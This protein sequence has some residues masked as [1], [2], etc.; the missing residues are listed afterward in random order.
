MLPSLQMPTLSIPFHAAS[1][2]YGSLF[3]PVRQSLVDLDVQTCAV[4]VSGFLAA[5]CV[6]RYVRDRF[7]KHDLK[8]RTVFITG[9]DTGFGNLLAKHLDKR[10]AIVVA[11]CLT[12]SGRQQLQGE[13]SPRLKTISLD[14]TKAESIR[15]ARDFV[16]QMSPDGVWSIVNNAGILDTGFAE[17][18]TLNDY[19]RVI[20]VN[21]LGTVAVTLDF[22]PLVRKAH[23]RI[24]NV[25]SVAGRLSGPGLASYSMS[26]FGVEAFS[27]SLRAE[28]AGFGVS[29]HIIEPG[30][31]KT[32][33]VD[34]QVTK[35]ILAR[36]WDGLSEPVKAAYGEGYAE[37]FFESSKELIALAQDPMNIVHAMT[38]AIT[39]VSPH[40]RYLVGLDANL[41]WRWLAASPECVSDWIFAVLE[42][43]PPTA[44]AAPYR[45]RENFVLGAIWRALPIAAGIGA[46]SWMRSRA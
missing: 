19:R 21:T 37:A 7:R 31:A 17:W 11:G 20:E 5:G 24:V 32:P 23:G 13:S 34:E 30:F 9:C 42:R 4:F 27:D 16:A 44:E 25:A 18:T 15:A 1:L 36:K 6:V 45:H 22:L 12:E 3:T 39:A 41:L 28:V 10:G 26:K 43:L 8:G 38:H 14:V 40:P 2:A 35:R 33:L 29:V 46:V